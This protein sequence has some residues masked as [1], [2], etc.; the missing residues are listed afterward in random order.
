MNKLYLT[1][2]V[3]L[4]SAS[5]TT[6]SKFIVTHLGYEPIE[7]NKSFVYALPKTCLKVE[8]NYQKDVF[9]PG[10]YADYA[11]RMLGIDGVKKVRS[12]VFRL[13]SAQVEVLT[14]PDYEHLYTVNY[15]EG[16]SKLEFFDWASDKKLILHGDYFTNSSI[17]T[18]GIGEEQIGLLYKDVTMESNLEM[19]QQTI[20]KTII[21]DTSFLSV[22]VTSQQMERK[23]VEKK[24]EEA[25][26]LV[27]EIRSDRYFIAAGLVDPFPNNFDMKTALESLDKLEEDYLSLFIGKSYTENL[28]KEYLICPEGDLEK[29]I[30]ELDGFVSGKGI[31]SEDGDPIMLT[32]V[33]D[34]N[35]KSFRNLLAQQPENSSFNTL[36]Y[37][38]PEVCKV[39]VSY[40]DKS[41]YNSRLSIFQSGALIS[42]KVGE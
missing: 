13:S 39:A 25:A 7:V 2:I 11:Q 40:K 10:P 36:F 32:L 42:E 22:P 34:G 31:Q 17:K 29:E 6:T 12:Q 23:T 24:A 21:T 8:V 15:L 5:C 27:L 14:E 33:P 18:Y 3:L 26:R 28:T 16:T 30:Y 4:I 1:A 35:S 37:R 9:I 19:K 41:L 38:I 20:Y